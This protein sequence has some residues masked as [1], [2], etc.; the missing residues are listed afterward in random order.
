MSKEYEGIIDLAN[1]ASELKGE[2][3]RIDAQMD[4]GENI[5]DKVRI[6]DISAAAAEG[7]KN[8]T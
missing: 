4:S 6:A 7:D 2:R 8:K 1:Q 5:G 3:E